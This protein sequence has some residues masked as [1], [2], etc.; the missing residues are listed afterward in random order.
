MKLYW[1][2]FLLVTWS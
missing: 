1:N 2:Y